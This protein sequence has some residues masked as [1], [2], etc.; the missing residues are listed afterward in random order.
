MRVNAQLKG[1]NSLIGLSAATARAEWV[2]SGYDGLSY[3][4]NPAAPLGYVVSVSDTRRHWYAYIYNAAGECRWMGGSST[5]GGAKYIVERETGI[6][7]PAGG[8]SQT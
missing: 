7:S 8:S 3:L 1:R 6:A 4:G 5:E 2:P